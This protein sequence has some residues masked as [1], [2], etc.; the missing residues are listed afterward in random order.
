MDGINDN[1]DDDT[2]KYETL[3]HPANPE[4]P[5][6]PT[7][8]RDT[9]PAEDQPKTETGEG[10]DNPLLEQAQQRP[11]DVA[12]TDMIHV[13]NTAKRIPEVRARHVSTQ[14]GSFMQRIGHPQRGGFSA[15]APPRDKPQHDQVAELLRRLDEAE[16]TIV[17]QKLTRAQKP[18]DEKEAEI[19]RLRAE[20]RERDVAVRAA[21]TKTKETLANLSAM[22]ATCADLKT[23]RVRLAAKLSKLQEQDR[24][25]ERELQQAHVLAADFQNEAEGLREALEEARQG[26]KRDEVTYREELGKLKRVAAEDSVS[27]GVIS[28]QQDEI[29]EYKE[30]NRVLG[31]SLEEAKK[32]GD[33]LQDKVNKATAE[34]NKAI[35]N[36]DKTMAEQKLQLEELHK[37]ISSPDPESHDEPSRQS[38]LRGTI[39]RFQDQ[40]S[41]AQ[42]IVDLK[43]ELRQRDRE[44]NQAKERETELEERL[45][46]YQA[47]FETAELA[48][49]SAA[50]QNRLGQELGEAREKT[51]Q[52]SDERKEANDKLAKMARERDEA[53]AKIER[54]NK[55]L[56]DAR[57]RTDRLREEID[58]TKRELAKARMA[59]DDGEE[60]DSDDTYLALARLHES[61]ENYE[62]L[63]EE[64]QELRSRYK[65]LQHKYNQRNGTVER[66]EEELGECELQNKQAFIE[67]DETLDEL[68]D[69]RERIE[70]LEKELKACRRM[71]NER[72]GIHPQDP[73]QGTEQSAREM[74][75]EAP[76]LIDDDMEL[77]YLRRAFA[78]SQ[79]SLTL[80]QRKAEEL[81]RKLKSLQGHTQGSSHPTAPGYV[82]SSKPFK[83]ARSRYV[84]HDKAYLTQCPDI[85]EIMRRQAERKDGVA[86]APRLDD[87]EQLTLKTFF[88][89]LDKKRD[90]LEGYH[91][92]RPERDKAW[93]PAEELKGLLHEYRDLFESEASDTGRIQMQNLHVIIAEVV[94]RREGPTDEVEE[95]LGEAAAS[96][97]QRGHGCVTAHHEDLS[98]RFKEA[99]ADAEE[100]RRK[101]SEQEKRTCG[102]WFVRHRCDEHGLSPHCGCEWHGVT[103]SC[104]MHQA[105]WADRAIFMPVSRGFPDDTTK[106][107]P[108]S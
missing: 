53:Q 102:C 24:T 89:F 13:Q 54:A 14:Y 46:K 20:V 40:T 100:Y 68:R 99:Q 60:R 9:A 39:S 75:K 43:Q 22:N 3:T 17:Q 38:K 88:G 49:N 47:I 31:R 92:G 103:S 78:I 4:I 12:D 19:A 48:A 56:T 83:S 44:L 81:E 11:D 66:L 74:V 21:V 91:D 50:E 61:E 5:R 106:V 80:S 73:E 30:A 62:K 65:D 97:V 6:A 27:K 28:S 52:V 90:I 35:A 84:E 93:N 79:Q 26:R 25:K 107:S 98:R 94:F 7:T 63:E 64:W 45:S 87:S 72:E 41:S 76:T 18:A 34:H 58:K 32:R 96:G 33:R 55:D 71:Y 36:R 85:E 70:E 105:K 101:K 59:R 104:E 77:V 1:P 23:G 2:P 51:K 86:G 15:S 108:P 69:E 42:E 67:L 57:T 10:G 37:Q 16:Q 82:Q 95:H 8:P 29:K